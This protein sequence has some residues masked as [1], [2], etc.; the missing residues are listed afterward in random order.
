MRSRL[1][2]L[3]TAD[4]E[5]PVPPRLYGGIERILDALVR[6]F[7]ARG[8]TVG[9]VAHADSTAPA[10]V[11]YPW[12]T[13]SS[14]GPANAWAN[15]PV[16]RRA[17]QA[18]QP[19]VLH[20]HSRLLWLLALLADP[21]PKI[22]SYQREPTGRSIRWSR[23]LHRG[24]LVFT[25]ISDYIS[26]AGRARGGG[27]WTTVPNFVDTSLYTFQPS[28]HDDAPLVFLSRI[29]AIKGCH[30]AIAI[31]KGAGRRLLIAGNHYE[32]GEAGAYWRERI[33]P[34][35]GRNGI[36]YVGPVNDAQKNALLGQAA[37]LVVPIEWN[38]PFGIV[39]AESLACGTPVISCPRGAL[40]EI[41]TPGEHG[42]LITSLEE[43][44][45]AVARLGTIDRAKCRAQVERK[46]SVDVVA[47][48]F[49][50][51]YR[52]LLDGRPA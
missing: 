17:L 31:A 47:E 28:V 21:T 10:A 24:R 25:G 7:T 29:E 33:L 1:R 9:L 43:G 44:L 23:R 19:D 32:D 36:E 40:P 14:L 39:F 42:F 11:R 3:L 5:L 15:A 52:R 48:Q 46:Y 51:L 26:A 13:A 16:L 50:A 34:E 2:I 38:E 30:T 22:M 20:S 35:L 18:F 8:H 41:V 49:L 45:A 4:A 27:D 6:A 37:A 12:A